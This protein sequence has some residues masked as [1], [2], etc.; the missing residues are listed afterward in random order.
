MP[1]P[2]PSPK[3]GGEPAAF[4]PGSRRVP[5]VPGDYG[6]PFKNGALF[7]GEKCGL[8]LRREG[9]DLLILISQLLILSV[10]IQII[11]IEDK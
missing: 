3:S 10:L 9:L 11:P 4:R 6:L 8:G 7:R 1:R 5:P 2:R